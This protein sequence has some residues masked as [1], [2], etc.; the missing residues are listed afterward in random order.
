VTHCICIAA[1]ADGFELARYIGACCCCRCLCI[2]PLHMQLQQLPDAFTL[3]HCM[4]IVEAAD[5]FELACCIGSYCCRCLHVGP[6]HM[7]LQQMPVDLCWP[8]AHVWWELPITSHWPIAYAIAAAADR[9]VLA[10]CI[11]SC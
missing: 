4:Q 2:G 11:C 10:C 5:G 8:I 1:A 9:V 3:A 6:L 7:Q